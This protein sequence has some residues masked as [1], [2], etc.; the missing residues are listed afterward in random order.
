MSKVVVFGG[1]G[2][3]GS[4]VVREAASRGHE[5]VSVSRSKP[6]DPID[7]VHYEIG[8]AEEVAA[9]VI[10]GAD[11]VV[12][13]LA[14]RGDMAGRLPEVYQ[15][16]AELSADAGARYLQVGG[17]SSLR[18]APGQ[19]RFVEGDIDEQYRDE[20]LEG[21]ATRVMLVERAPAELDWVFFSPAAGF[22]AWA[23]GERT[24]SYRIGDDVA[25]FDEAGGSTISGADFAVAIVDEIDNPRHSRA[26]VGVAY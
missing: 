14:P 15:R 24:G 5:V 18:P 2:Y 1:T 12:A 19:P 9:D 23:A 8:S 26:H 4:N 7:G 21:E 25:L 11:A 10:A 16:L 3:A 17:F 6:E 13:A 20:A 22:G